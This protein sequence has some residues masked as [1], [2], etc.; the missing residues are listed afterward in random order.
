MSTNR[1]LEGHADLPQALFPPPFPGHPVLQRDGVMPMMPFIGVRI[2]W[3]MRGRNSLLAGWPAPPG[4]WPASS[5]PLGTQQLRCSS[6]KTVICW[7][8][9]LFSTGYPVDHQINRSSPHRY[10]D[11]A[12]GNTQCSSSSSP[13]RLSARRNARPLL[14]DIGFCMRDIGSFISCCS[15]GTPECAHVGNIVLPAASGRERADE[16]DGYP[17][18][19]G[20]ADQRSRFCRRDFL[21]SDAADLRA[22]KFNTASTAA[23]VRMTKI[24]P[25]VPGCLRCRHICQ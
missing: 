16:E 2:S 8:H 24:V 1:C 17:H 21:W 19:S 4:R 12:G 5:S 25:A 20:P 11:V 9:P 7:A 14:L 10:E 22:V 6:V 18:G 3:D 15:T 13:R 23:V